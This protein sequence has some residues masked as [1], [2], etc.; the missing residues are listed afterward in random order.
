MESVGN[1][2]P[3]FLFELLV[4]HLINLQ[5][6]AEKGVSSEYMN[7]VERRLCRKRRQNAVVCT[8]DKERGV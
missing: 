5:L 7:C 6:K 1:A 2:H 3:R 4:A 8:K